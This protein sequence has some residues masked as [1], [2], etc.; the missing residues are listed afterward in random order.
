MT[1]KKLRSSL[2]VLRRFHNNFSEA[3]DWLKC[4]KE[5]G[6]NIC[7]SMTGYNLKRCFG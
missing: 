1:P 7:H 5:E 3:R 6:K 4:F 2:I